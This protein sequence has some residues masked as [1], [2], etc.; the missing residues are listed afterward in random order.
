MESLHNCI[1]ELQQQA[2]AQRLEL[3]DAHHGYV[4]PRREQ[5]RQQEE[6]AVREKPIRDTQIRGI[7]EIGEMKR[8]Q[9]SRVDEF[10]L[11]K[12]RESHET[13]QRL[14][15]QV[16]E[17]QA[18]VNYLSGSGEFQEVESNYSGNFSRVSS[19]PARIPS[20]R[21]TLSCDKR[22]PPDT[23]NP[24]GLQENVFANP[25]STLETSQTPY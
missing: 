20:P 23:W 17:L 24:S 18:R 10:S 21:S 3:E 5:V 11:Q 16:Q 4:D 19:Q 13:M 22:L 9:E 6:L 2:Y 15:S 7:H 8:A 25:R 12:L 1:S 14:T